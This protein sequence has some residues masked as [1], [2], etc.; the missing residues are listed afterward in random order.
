MSDCWII[1]T[2]KFF[3]HSSQAAAE[4]EY[5]RLR[6]KAP[7]KSFTLLRVKSSV[8]PSRSAKII[9]AL[10]ESKAELLAALKDATL[11]LA[12]LAGSDEG[13][14][15][16]LNAARAAIAKAEGREAQS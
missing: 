5:E 13:H 1:T 4:K 16:Y 2:H 6:A 15:K 14:E 10:E 11:A 9:A 12:L 3:R 7:E 8:A